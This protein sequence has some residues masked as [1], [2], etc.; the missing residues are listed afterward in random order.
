MSDNRDLD[1]VVFIWFKNARLN[2]ILVNAKVIKEK[3]E[4]LFKTSV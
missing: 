3:P 2:N 4:D 1:K